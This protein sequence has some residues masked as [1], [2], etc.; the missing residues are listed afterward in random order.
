MGSAEMKTDRV[1]ERNGV[2]LVAFTE[3]GTVLA[4]CLAEA[5]GGTVREEGMPL[6]AWVKDN[7]VA[8]EALI[9]VGAVGIAVRAVA[10]W[11]RSKATDPAVV[12]VDE[13]GRWAVSVL[14]GHLG[15]ANELT[16][17]IAELTGAEAVITT[18]TDRNGVFAVDL[19]AKKQELTVLQPDRIRQVSAKLLR[20]ETV[21]VACQ[22]QIE[23][24]CPELIRLGSPHEADVSVSFRREKGP[25]LQLVPRVLALG[26]G[27]R[28]GI[29]EDIMEE[30]FLRFCSERGVFPQ[31]VALAAS[32]DRK[33]EEQG[34]LR[35][36]ENHAWPLQFF[37]TE[38]LQ[39]AEGEFSASEFVKRTVGVSNVCERAAVLASGGNLLEKKYAGNGVTFALAALPAV[40]DWSV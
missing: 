5:L 31:A 35:F 11:I 19:W 23:G 21:S 7:I 20:G 15:G 40:Y 39:T 3:R 28:K 29:Q 16:R 37:R 12:C 13:T 38:E 25:A 9:F 1:P 22:W 24:R 30:E 26:I 10:P 17:K 6:S 27:C 14:S 32:I 8:R 33:R 18:A 4:R 34:L 36:C 2:A